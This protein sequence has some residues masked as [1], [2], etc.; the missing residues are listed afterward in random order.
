MEPVIERQLNNGERLLWTGKPD[1]GRTALKYIP[2]SI[3]AVFWLGMCTVIFGGMAF[4][5]GGMSQAVGGS[6][7]PGVGI[8][9]FMAIPFVVAGLGFLFSPV[10]AAIGA[11]NTVYG[12]TDSRLLIVKSF[13]STSVRTYRREDIRDLER[14]ERANGTGDLVFGR[15]ASY[16]ADGQRYVTETRLVG[17]PE[18][19]KV[20]QFLLEI[21]YEQSVEQHT[22][23]YGNQ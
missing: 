14:I 5:T 21:P 16:R 11:S 19:R 18:V 20:E 23:Q 22:Q 8:T 13:I 7:M 9:S 6:M 2:F 15:T 17:I 12:I 1:A 3:F 4:V 10:L